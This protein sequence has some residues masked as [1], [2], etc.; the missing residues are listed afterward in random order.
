MVS[1]LIINL[2]ENIKESL[3]N[4]C[5]ESFIFLLMINFI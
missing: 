1:V 5:F 3:R 2:S 4:S